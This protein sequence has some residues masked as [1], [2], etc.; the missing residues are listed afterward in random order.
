V[1]L[2]DRRTGLRKVCAMKILSRISLASL[3]ALVLFISGSVADAA[4]GEK[5]KKTS[6]ESS[7]SSAVFRHVVCFK[8]KAGT[9]A[10]KISEIEEKFAALKDKIDTIK[11]FEWGTSESV[12]GLNKDF[13]HCFVV[14]F[15]DKAGLEAYI[16]HE[17]HQ[18]FVAVLKPHLDDVFVFDY[19]SKR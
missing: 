19:T 9:S 3:M 18:A 5:G 7:K 2:V 12:E 4:D 16:P 11:D 15:A 1:F 8:F 13:S 10:E 14:T 6:A 17:A